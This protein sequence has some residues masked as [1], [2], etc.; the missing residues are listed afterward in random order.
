MADNDLR[1]R[2]D[3]TI[4]FLKENLNSVRAGRANPAILDKLNVEYYGTQ[5]PIKAVANISVPDPHTLMI[6]PFDPSAIPDIEKAIN[7]SNIG[8]NPAN[9][10]KVIR[11]SIPS[12]TEERRKELT[13]LVKNFGEEAKVSVRNMRR[14]LNDDVKKRE[15][16]GE[17]TEDD[18]RL[19][20]DEIQKQ[21]EDAIKQI[22][23]IIEAKDKEL[24]E[25]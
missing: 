25:V 10:G 24:L 2:V 5:S 20:L 18:V 9:D 4:D 13:K 11:L 15:K 17:L 19:E 16:Q 6:S 7:E 22:D 12:L 21:T 1:T 14:D 3:K 8:I 23:Q